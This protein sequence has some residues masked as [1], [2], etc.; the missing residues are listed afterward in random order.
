MHNDILRCVAYHP[1]WEE[2]L[3]CLLDFETDVNA[4]ITLRVRLCDII[5]IHLI[6]TIVP[7]AAAVFI[8]IG[9]ESKVIFTRS[10]Q[11]KQTRPTSHGQYKTRFWSIQ[12]RV[13]NTIFYLELYWHGGYNIGC[14]MSLFTRSS[15]KTFL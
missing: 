15:F 2:V 11:I 14:V 5:T 10:M 6:C 1:L 7:T 12:Y 3:T 8:S 4:T 9:L 13:N